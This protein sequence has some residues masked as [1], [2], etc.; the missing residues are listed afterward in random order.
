[1]K[2]PSDDPGADNE[3]DILADGFDD[4]KKK[5]PGESAVRP[6]RKLGDIS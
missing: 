2:A 5:P 1:L 4:K 6:R 3:M